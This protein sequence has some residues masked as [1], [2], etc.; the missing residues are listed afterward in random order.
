MAWA[1]R[2]RDVFPIDINRAERRMLY[3]MPE[4]V[5]ALKPSGV[6]LLMGTNDLEEGAT[7]EMIAGRVQ[8]NVRRILLEMLS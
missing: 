7:P 2:S 4:D 6:V 1:L 5:L 3:R 8:Q